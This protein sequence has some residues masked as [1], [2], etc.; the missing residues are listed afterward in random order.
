[1]N[2]AGRNSWT[3]QGEIGSPRVTSYGNERLADYFITVSSAVDLARPR[4]GRISRPLGK[5][6]KP[7]AGLVPVGHL[8]TRVDP[9]SRAA[10][11]GCRSVFLELLS[12]SNHRGVVRP[13]PKPTVI[14]AELGFMPKAAPRC[15]VMLAAA[16]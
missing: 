5:R 7:L 15:Q 9:W 4:V 8:V 16:Y 3:T 11:T 1:M 14:Q 13:R 10:E 6:N 12:K 2:S